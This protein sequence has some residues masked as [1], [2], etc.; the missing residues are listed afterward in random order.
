[1]SE[2]AFATLESSN[3]TKKDLDNSSEI[4]DTTRYKSSK[5]IFSKDGQFSSKLSFDKKIKIHEDQI[6]IDEDEF[7]EDSDYFKLYNLKKD[8]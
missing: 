5:N 8:G 2:Q 6:I 1:M 3:K 7:W 4:C